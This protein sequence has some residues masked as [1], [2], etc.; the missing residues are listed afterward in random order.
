MKVQGALE[1]SETRAIKVG[2]MAGIESGQKHG[3][4]LDR[5]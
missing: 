5:R 3:V 1:D 2:R 4:L